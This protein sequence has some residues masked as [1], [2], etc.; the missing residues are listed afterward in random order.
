MSLIL[1]L[2]HGPRTQAMREARLD[3][4]ELLIGRSSEADW[5]IEDPDM[6]VSRAHCRITGDQ[7]GYF[8]TDLSSSGLFIDG[9]PD[10][11]G[12]GNSTRLRNGMRLRLGDYVLWVEVAAGG[13][14]QP[15]PSAA[16]PAPA[17]S[18]NLESDDFFS[19]RTEEEPA[20][21]R[22]SDL[23]TP[24]EQQRTTGHQ[25]PPAAGNRN[26]PAFDDPFSLDPLASP[27]PG[28]DPFGGSAKP[29]PPVERTAIDLPQGLD[30]F[31]FG[32]SR[33]ETFGQAAK[34][35]NGNPQPAAKEPARPDPWELPA[36]APAPVAPPP[37]S[38]ARAPDPPAAATV[39]EQALRAAF[40]RG[41]GLPDHDAADA[42]PIAEMERLGREY[43]LM[44]D[45]LM[46]LL[47]KRAEEKNNAR[48]AQTVV[49]S[50]EVNPLKFLPGVDDA[51]AV[52][53]SG[54]SPGFLNGE[55]AIIDS[56]R[57]LAGHHVRA[58]RGVQG[59]LR[60]MIDRFDPA[61]IEEELKSGSTLGAA[62]SGGRRA[63]LWELYRKR[64][65]EI[66]QSAETRFLG[67]IGADFRD[68][69]EEE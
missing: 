41:L 26:G 1:K 44:M 34:P 65:R 50:T 27:G 46:Q 60:R 13:D 16:R 68:A 53:L 29:R 2:E 51:L 45:G 8:V 11:L 47:R 6:F 39:S 38:V 62:L 48:V 40:M 14:A 32:T 28:N 52:V 54:R 67:E 21:P 33:S 30:D 9:S 36:P 12:S 35:A 58:W 59:A 66:A 25:P 18:S 17:N 5:Q 20:R 63:M 24:F 31:S 42:D 57:D 61:A 64:H 4:G 55:A 7:S 22:P 23:P 37:P 15:A 19:I 10:P 49:G 43:R 56:V 69:Y 3:K